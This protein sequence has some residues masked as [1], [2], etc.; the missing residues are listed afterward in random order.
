[1]VAPTFLVRAM[2][3]KP[4]G[5]VTSNWLPPLPWVGRKKVRETRYRCYRTGPPRWLPRVLGRSETLMSRRVEPRC[6]GA[7][8]NG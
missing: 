3:R 7:A 1:M 6:R 8:T 5:W 2:P 4:L